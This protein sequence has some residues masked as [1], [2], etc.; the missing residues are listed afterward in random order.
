MNPRK[1]GYMNSAHI[2]VLLILFQVF[3]SSVALTAG[4]GP[5]RGPGSDITVTAITSHT[6]GEVVSLSPQRFSASLSNTGSIDYGEDVN[7]TLTISY[8]ANDTA[9]M[10][11]VHNETIETGRILEEVGNSTLVEFSP[12]TPINEGFFLV[13]VTADVTDDHPDNDTLS[14]TI[15]ATA[16]QLD[17]VKVTIAPGSPK[18]QKIK[19]GENTKMAGYEPY[20]FR[21]ENTGM[22]NDTFGITIDSAWVM[23]GWD[24]TTRELAPGEFDLIR[25]DVEV[26]IDASPISFDVLIFTA[27]SGNN[28]SMKD[29]ENVTTS[30]PIKEGVEV[31]VISQDP[32]VGYPGGPPVEFSFMVRNTGDWATSYTL[33]VTSRPSTWKAELL[34]IPQTD[35]IP[36]GS[37]VIAYARIVLPTLV[38][39]TM[40]QDRTEEGQTGALIMTAT[41]PSG[42]ADSAE[43]TV[44]V[45]LVHTVQM[46][47]DPEN[48]TIPFTE[49]MKS[50]P[51]FINITVRVRSIN[52]N[53]ADPGAEMEVNLST[54]DGPSGVRFKP[55]WS[56]AF[57]ETLS[58]TWS[59]SPPAGTIHLSSGEWSQGQFVRVIGPPFPFQGTA[60]VGI[61]A[62]P[63]LT[64]E[65]Q[66]LAIPASRDATIHI[67]PYLDHGIEPPRTEFFDDPELDIDDDRDRNGIE[68]WRE[69]APGETLLL[70][71]NVTNRGN[72]WDRYLILGDAIPVEPTTL[73]PDDWKMDLPTTTRTL[74]PFNFAPA[75]PDHSQLVWVEVTIPDGAPIGESAVIKVGAA[76]KITFDEQGGSPAYKWA[77]VTVHVLQGFGVDIEPEQ[78]SRSAEPLETVAYRLNVTNT[79]NGIDLVR[80]RIE[81][82][83]IEGWNITFDI[84]EMKLV[85]LERRTLTIRVTPDLDAVKDDIL[86]LKVRGQSTIS[87]D[88]FDDVWVNTTVRYRGGVRLELLDTPSLIWRY[89]G[90]T[91]TFL[92]ELTNK[93]NGNDTFDLSLDVENPTWGAS[94]DSEE[95]G[96]SV[97]IPR[98]EKRQLRINITLPSLDTL[99]NEE[100][101][102]EKGINA[103]NKVSTI[104]SAEPREDPGTGG[105]INLTVGVLQDHRASVV[106]A[107]GENTVKEVLVGESVKFMLL[108]Q[109][110]GNGEDR[111]SA[112]PHS[113]SGS[114]RHLS[115]VDLDGGPYTLRPFS[116]V[117]LNLSITPAILDK[118]L[119]DERVDMDVEAVAGDNLTYRRVNLSAMITLARK[120]ADYID[121]DLGDTV[122]V[123][124]RICN[125][126]DPGEDPVLELP[127]QRTYT[128]SSMLSR[129]G[130]YSE[131]WAI[132][133]KEMNVTL[134]GYYQLEDVMIPVRGPPELLVSA[135]TA[136]VSVDVSDITAGLE[137]SVSLQA[138]LRAVYFDVEIDREK[139]RFQN[140][141]EGGRGRAYLTIVATGNRG[142]DTIPVLVKLDGEIVGSMD[143]GPA[144]P[145]DY[146]S[147]EL[148][149]GGGSQE[150][151][152]EIEFDLPGLKWYEKGRKMDL[153]V[154]L[155]PDG[156]IRENKAQGG[157]EAEN[158]N[159]MEKEFAIKNY[160]PHPA[161]WVLAL[162]LL[163]LM[164]IA[165]FIG[166]FFTGRKESWFLVL[167]GV[168]A[169]GS[170]GLMFFIPLEEALSIDTANR[171]GLAII[172]IDLVFIMPIMIY[173]FTKAGDPYI[174][175]LINRRRGD[176]PIEGMKATSSIAKPLAISLLGGLL[177]VSIPLLFWVIP[178]ELDRGIGRVVEVLTSADNGLPVLVLI[179]VIPVISVSLQGGLLFMKTRALKRINRTWDDLERLRV[180]IEGGFL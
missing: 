100:E 118:P 2:M 155:D 135:P 123:P 168:G 130:T 41:S 59:A 156:V 77:E 26:P 90:E 138:F 109:N 82:P 33:T 146:Y 127:H 62:T 161:I 175:H 117:Y 180:E 96:G 158:N 139:T 120:I 3:L 86:A 152:L 81:S 32:Q 63:E 126:P 97:D 52:N 121:V 111:I 67:G 145:Q 24:D 76:S 70:P 99:R 114:V 45:G 95:R 122:Y 31:S 49:E 179:L 149:A 108:L 25:V 154:V 8:P 140:L 98:G 83:D 172:L 107:P 160:V 60:I 137:K 47:V 9:N 87:E 165:G 61:T 110:R 176:D 94:I 92:V 36:V 72:G 17:D 177:M 157:G 1:G 40:D 173:L 58:A 22:R 141:F 164:M 151:I 174:L 142:Q 112:I 42:V 113:P 20:V 129:S 38:P 159:I 88:A 10:T 124:I 84:Q 34:S 30:I 134:T 115:W 105:R 6:D 153:Q 171:I 68:D 106:I 12:W 85:P 54:P 55:I 116:I 73:L 132:P 11:E 53:R 7:V 89:P 66:G 125:M 65:R 80:F 178:S 48:L 28:A 44:D 23:P 15:L 136:L 143:A 37:F 16:E 79:G 19:R 128:V 35:T 131:G 39:E 50:S 75:R 133:E 91:A 46:E 170:F 78:S 150:M 21:V 169:A 144:N 101:L 93:G 69:G 27:I 102:Y 51:Q 13:E 56:G 166:Y 148:P 74:I 5:S 29:S 18:I 103:L 162:I 119:W 71:F 167:L 43:G 57:N 14:I 4:G 104:L 147:A 64:E 163:F